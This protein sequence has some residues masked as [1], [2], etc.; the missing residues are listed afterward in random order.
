MARIGRPPLPWSTVR[1]GLRAVALGATRVEAARIAGMG[2]NT[3]GRYV[4]IHG[5]GV[6]RGR[7]PRANALTIADREEVFLGI[8]RNES[9]AE[10]GSRLGCHR[11]TVWREITANGGRRAYRPHQ[12]QQRVDEAARRCRRPWT[13]TRPWLWEEVQTQLRTQQWS[14]EQI[15]SGSVGSIPTSQS[16]GSHTSRSTKRSLCKPRGNCARSSP[17]VCVPGGLGVGR[18]AGPAGQD[19]RSSG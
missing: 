7:T 12:A 17:P 2:K 4:Q 8:E 15:A 5:V 11:C 16:G 9:V 13:E 1:E 6:L 3:L 14:P 10:I 19:R 18:G